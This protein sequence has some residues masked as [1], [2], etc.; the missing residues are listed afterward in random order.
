MNIAQEEKNRETEEESYNYIMI[1]YGSYIIDAI[2]LRIKSGKAKEWTQKFLEK[3]CDA[4]PI[5]ILVR[6]NPYRTLQLLWSEHMRVAL[7]GQTVKRFLEMTNL[8]DEVSEEDIDSIYIEK[9]VRVIPIAPAWIPKNRILLELLLEYVFGRITEDLV[10]KIFYSAFIKMF[11][12]EDILSI[13]DFS[14]WQRSEEKE[15]SI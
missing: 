13:N 2:I 9:G 4:I 6:V 14:N 3:N 15:S 1:P 5:K 12:R 7:R 8:V 10:K 11:K